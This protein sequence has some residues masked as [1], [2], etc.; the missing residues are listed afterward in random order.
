MLSD[1]DRFYSSNE[2]YLQLYV[3]ATPTQLT[4]GDATNL[5]LSDGWLYYTAGN[6]IW[7]MSPTGGGAEQFYTFSDRISQMYVMGQQ[8]RFMSNGALYSL[9]MNDNTLETLEAPAGA[10]KFMPTPYGDVF[11]TGALF[12]Y[13]LVVGDSQL[14]SGF[15]QCYT[16]GDWL[17]VQM[18][19]VMYQ[20]PLAD[21]FAGSVNLQYYSLHQ[22]EIVISRE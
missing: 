14:L 12:N 2:G 5:N 13:S 18:G 22:N 17:I 10:V 6:S 19:G 9:D 20:A 3:G 16:E 4:N 21:V 7:R 11:F 1:G 8:I 15:D